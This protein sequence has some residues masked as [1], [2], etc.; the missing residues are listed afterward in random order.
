MFAHAD[1]FM[2]FPQQ[3][4]AN[5][6]PVFGDDPDQAVDIFCVVT[7]QFGELLH[8]RFEVFEPPLEAFLVLPRRLFSWRATRLFFA[9]DDISTSSFISTPSNPPL[10]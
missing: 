10:E 9:R 3:L 8:L 1:L 5:C 7:D 6:V 4:L 2:V